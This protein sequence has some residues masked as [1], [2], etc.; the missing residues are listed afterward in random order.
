MLTIPGK[1]IMK[2][3]LENLQLS[4]HIIELGQVELNGEL[5]KEQRHKLT[6][7]LMECGLELMEDKRQ[8]LVEMI[9][10]A[11]VDMVYFEEEPPQIKNS[12]YISQKLQYDYTYLA[13]VFSE[14][15]GTTLE[16]FIIA[17]KIERVKELLLYD[18]YTLTMIAYKL[19]YSSVAH[20]SN[21]FKK[22]TGITPTYFRQ[23]EIKDLIPIEQV[24]LG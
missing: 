7:A 17:H 10:K 18:E 13:N 6:K 20:L 16:R 4:Y 11:V 1:M 22:V 19:N 12:C 8:V 2:T 24:G 21:Q 3:I 14:I 5:T 23:L 15:M 9:K